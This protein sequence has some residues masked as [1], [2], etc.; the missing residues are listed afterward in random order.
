MRNTQIGKKLSLTSVVDGA[1]S[2]GVGGEGRVVPV[3]Q[4][5]LKVISADNPGLRY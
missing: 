5:G 1:V 4:A 3:I 2:A